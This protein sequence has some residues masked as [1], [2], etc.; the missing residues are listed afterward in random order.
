MIQALLTSSQTGELPPRWLWNGEELK[1]K[2]RASRLCVHHIKVCSLC[3]RV[4]SAHQGCIYLIKNTVKI[5]ILLLIKTTVL[6][7]NIY[8][9]VIYFC[10]AQLYF[11]HHYCSLQCH[12]IFRN[13]NNMLKKHSDISMLKI[14]V[15]ATIF[16]W[17]LRYI[18][19]SGFTDE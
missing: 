9:T 12:M 7:V 15:P 8:E 1:K 19:F 13:H 3:E 10:D 18:N 16:L 6:Y 14:V 5:E 4:S 17:K 11:Q 2:T